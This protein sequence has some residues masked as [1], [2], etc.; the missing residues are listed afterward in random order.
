MNNEIIDTSPP[1]E[2]ELLTKQYLDITEKNLFFHKI[3]YTIFYRTPMMLMM[4]ITLFYPTS[5]YYH[6]VCFILTYIREQVL[7]MLGH[8]SVHTHFNYSKPNINGMG[9]FCFGAYIHHYYNPLI[10]SQMNFYSYCNQYIECLHDASSFINQHKSFT[11]NIICLFIPLCF[12][13]PNNYGL[14]YLSVL[15]YNVGMNRI[16]YLFIVGYVMKFYNVDNINICIYVLYEIFHGYLQAITHLWYHTLKSKRKQ[17]FGLFLFYLMSFLENIQIVSSKIH[18]IHHKHHLHNLIEVEVWNN[19]YVP[20]FIHNYV[21][22]IFKYITQLNVENNVK[23]K[24]GIRII[25]FFQIIVF[26][27][28]TSTILVFINYL[29]V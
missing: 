11:K 25:D 2:S 4:Y 26:I 7:F 29:S 17:H 5:F 3:L 22:N 16:Y 13:I 9:L 14:V 15:T 19:L 23:I 27:S 20:R 24:T 12:I 28:F 6:I 10:H 18:K 21:D 1:N 8:L